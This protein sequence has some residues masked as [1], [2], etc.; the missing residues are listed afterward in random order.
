M[1]EEADTPETVHG[2]MYLQHSVQDGT[3]DMVVAMGSQVQIQQS[4]TDSHGCRD[5]GGVTKTQLPN[6]YLRKS[7]S[8]V[9]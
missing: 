9:K 2:V 8:K 1:E 3:M 5:G 7:S 6:Q 4:A